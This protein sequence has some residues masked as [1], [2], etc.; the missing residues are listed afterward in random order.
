MVYTV[1]IKHKA[2]GIVQKL[3]HDAKMLWLK[4][5]HWKTIS[6]QQLHKLS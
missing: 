4:D 3:L 1:R 2:Y 5:I 6:M